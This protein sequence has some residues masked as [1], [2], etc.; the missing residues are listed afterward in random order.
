MYVSA[1]KS[2]GTGLS[3]IPVDSIHTDRHNAQFSGVKD[4]SDTMARWLSRLDLHDSSA[5]T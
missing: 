5:E 4:R 2:I 3:F 1:R